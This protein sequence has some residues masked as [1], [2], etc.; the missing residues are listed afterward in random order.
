MGILAFTKGQVKSLEV[1]AFTKGSVDSWGF[2]LF[3]VEH[4]SL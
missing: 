3:T 4:D 1:F 2:I